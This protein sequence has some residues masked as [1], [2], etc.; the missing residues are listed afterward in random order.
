MSL[1]S[2]NRIHESIHHLRYCMSLGVMIFFNIKCPFGLF[3]LSCF[4]FVFPQ[5]N[6][7]LNLKK[8]LQGLIDG[9]V[10]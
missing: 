9:I 1:E 7:V 4:S 5:I 3:V 8:A 6:E 10:K 2:I